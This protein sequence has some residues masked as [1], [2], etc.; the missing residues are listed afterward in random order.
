MGEPTIYKPSIYKGVG[1]Y[2][3][4]DNGGGGGGGDLP[5]VEILG[6]KYHYI[7]I[8][9]YLYTA[10]NLDYI[11]SNLED[12]I[13]YHGDFYVKKAITP[14]GNIENAGRLYND[15]A[16]R[17]IDNLLLDTGWGCP[18]YNAITALK[19]QSITYNKSRYLQPNDKYSWIS[20]YEEP[21]GIY[22]FNA[23][24]VGTWEATNVGAPGRF[25][26]Q[27]KEARFQGNYSSSQYWFWIDQNQN[28]TNGSGS[29]SGTIARSI[30][31]CKYI[32]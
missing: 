15:W 2:K 23:L 20:T 1:I 5:E 14:P 8:G 25:V 11:D 3:T 30:R 7:Q 24:A 26:G 10:E 28:M 29:S 4:G 32:G 13:V 19:S 31:L 6:K 18:S 22:N 17:Y 9:M 12:D 16:S 27:G 21:N